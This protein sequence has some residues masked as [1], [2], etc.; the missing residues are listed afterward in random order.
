MGARAASSAGVMSVRFDDDPHLGLD[1]CLPSQWAAANGNGHWSPEKRMLL[2]M[3]VDTARIMRSPTHPEHDA[4]RRWVTGEGFTFVQV[5]GELGLNADRA[6]TVLLA[7]RSNGKQL[8]GTHV[9]NALRPTA[10]KD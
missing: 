2:E 4:T 1:A 8:R 9:C 5:C 10:L 7:A 6:R 3:L